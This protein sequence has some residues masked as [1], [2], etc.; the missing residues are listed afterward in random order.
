MVS[1]IIGKRGILGC[2][3]LGDKESREG[4]IPFEKNDIDILEALSSQAGIA[5]DNAKL[6]QEINAAKRFNESIMGSIATTVITVNLLGEIDTINKAGRDLFGDKAKQ[7]IGE[8]Y[9][10]FFSKDK[11]LCAAIDAACLLYTSPSPRD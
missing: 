6:F 3:V 2:I 11:N 4:V 9:S 8:H 7:I 1:P 10:F 5:M